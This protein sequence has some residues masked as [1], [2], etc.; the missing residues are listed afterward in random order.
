M[1]SIT[2]SEIAYETLARAIYRFP[3]GR[4]WESAFGKYAILNQMVSVQWGLMSNGSIDQEGASP[5]RNL[6]SESMDAALFLRDD[7]LKTTGQRIW[8]LA[9]TLYPDGKF[10][11]EHDYKKP[12]DYEETDETIDVSLTEFSN[13]L[14]KK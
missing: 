3:G 11:I 9:F 6:V 12:E 5:Q 10:N 14:N 13:K 4:A 2:T 7:L 8:G 1:T